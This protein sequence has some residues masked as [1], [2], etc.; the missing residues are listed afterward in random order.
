MQG[1]IHSAWDRITMR[2]L[3]IDGFAGSPV[4]TEISIGEYIKFILNGLTPKASKD[5]RKKWSRLGPAN[6]DAQI[7]SPQ[8]AA[9]LLGVA[10]S[11]IDRMVGD[12]TL[13]AVRF[14]QGQRKGLWG[15]SRKVLQK[16]IEDEEKQ[17]VQL[18][19]ERNGTRQT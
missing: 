8:Q 3:Y 12:Q 5:V 17:K 9:D 4:A 14:R 2:D 19:G 11:T 7:L 16:W 1:A 13:Q 10:R 6:P 15:I 18:T